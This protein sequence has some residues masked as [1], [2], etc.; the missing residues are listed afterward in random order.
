M[1]GADL[2]VLVP[3]SP[4]SSSSSFVLQRRFSTNFPDDD[5]ELPLQPPVD[6][7][8]L[9]ASRCPGFTAFAFLR[10]I[11]TCGSNRFS[12]R[13][14]GNPVGRLIG[15]WTVLIFASILFDP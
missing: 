7:R 13:E 8:L 2:V 15:M 3:L 5:S 12:I 1:M 9:N 4:S 10:N 6:V 14:Q 11:T